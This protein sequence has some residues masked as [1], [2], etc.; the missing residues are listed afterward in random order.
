M[1]MVYIF[2]TDKIVFDDYEDNTEEYGSY[3]VE[4]CM[5][6]RN[7]Y[8]DILGGRVDNGSPWG[9]CYVKGCNNDADCYVDFNKNE[10][11]FI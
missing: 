11:E 3:W 4:M 2:K 6:C 1:N 10:V 7:K 8:K 9:T 5:N